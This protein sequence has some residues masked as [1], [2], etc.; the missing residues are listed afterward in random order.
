[1]PVIIK[2]KLFNNFIEEEPMT[3]YEYNIKEN[4]CKFKCLK[5]GQRITA[6]I[7]DGQI[8]CICSLCGQEL[9]AD[10]RKGFWKRELMN[11]DDPEEAEIAVKIFTES[12]APYSPGWDCGC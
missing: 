12:F 4:K 2:K 1:M 9:K 5:C 3:T 11:L 7:R 10:F 6:D 8:N